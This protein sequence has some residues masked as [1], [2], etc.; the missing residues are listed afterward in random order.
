M[1]NEAIRTKSLEWFKLLRIYA[2]KGYLQAK[3]PSYFIPAL[4]LLATLDM[5]ELEEALVEF[6]KCYEKEETYFSW[7]QEMNSFINENTFD[8]QWQLLPALYKSAYKKIVSK[9]AISTCTDIIP[10]LLK[11]WVK[12][13]IH[14]QPFQRRRAY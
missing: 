9:E 8:Y 14:P 2:E 1:I 10:E 5:N 6:W 3:E 11:A 4:T 13:L 12:L 7:L